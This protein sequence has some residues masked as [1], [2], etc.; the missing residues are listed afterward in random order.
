MVN[1]SQSRATTYNN[2]ACYYRRTGKLRAALSYLGQA[3]ALEVR[4]EKPATLA[5]THLN[6]CAVLSQLNRHEDAQQHAML[7]IILIQDELLQVALNKL[8]KEEQSELIADDRLA[9]L[10]VSYHNLGVELEHLQRVPQLL[11]QIDEA[12]KIYNKALQ[13]TVDFTPNNKQLIRNLGRVV[14]TMTQEHHQL[15]PN[16]RP[17]ESKQQART[18]K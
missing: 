1:S 10:A 12:I 13:L 6:I 4:L 14:N 5:D 16:H 7:S 17:S 15:N 2:L 11:K 9:V 8:V 18:P 3:L